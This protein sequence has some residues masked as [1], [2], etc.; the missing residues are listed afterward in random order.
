[1]R[2]TRMILIALLTVGLLL[3][4]L[5]PAKGLARSSQTETPYC[6]ASLGHTQ[7]T[8]NANGTFTF[9]F[10]VKNVSAFPATAIAFSGVTPAGV[11]ISPNQALLSPP[12]PPNGVRLITVTISGPGAVSGPTAC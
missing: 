11:T 4:E 8:C 3:P 2:L 9:K 6:L 7:I 5:L 1:M 10:P 12:L